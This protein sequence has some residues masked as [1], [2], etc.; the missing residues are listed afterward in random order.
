LAALVVE[1][2]EH[3]KGVVIPAL[4]DV[5]SVLLDAAV[6]PAS[7]GAFAAQAPPELV[8]HHLV[9][10]LPARVAGELVRGGQPRG[11]AAEDR[12]PGLPETVAG[13]HCPV[14]GTSFFRSRNA[15]FSFHI[16]S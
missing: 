14:N 12:N 3:A 10:L 9:A 13:L 16:F 2:P 5:D 11:P 1:L 6:G 7:G 4:Q 8:H 15:C